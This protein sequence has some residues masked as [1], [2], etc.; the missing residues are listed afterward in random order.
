METLG[1]SLITYTRES[2][3]R[4]YM[5][6]EL[7]EPENFGDGEFRRTPSSDAYSFG[8]LILEVRPL[9]NSCG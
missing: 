2:G 9:T 6:P 4:A 8:S 1:P 7:L 3:G 5:G